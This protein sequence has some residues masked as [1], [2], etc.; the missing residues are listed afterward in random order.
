MFFCC[1]FIAAAAQPAPDLCAQ[2]NDERVIAGLAP[3]VVSDSLTYVAET[4]RRDQNTNYRPGALCTDH[5]WNDN[6]PYWTSCCYEMSRPN[7]Q[8]MFVKPAELTPFAA[9]GYE[10]SAYGCGSV[11]CLLGAW[12]RS[13]SHAKVIFARDMRSVGCAISSF[14]VSCCW[15][16]RDIDPLTYPGCFRRALPPIPNDRE[17]RLN[18]CNATTAVPT[19]SP[20]A[21]PTAVPTVS[22]TKRMHTPKPTRRRKINEFHS[23]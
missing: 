6:S 17:P 11:S 9:T 1:L 15:F 12:L 18:Q 19:M 3:L 14:K 4:H 7:S 8:C 10:I 13:P 20:T 16:S 23:Q 2:I 22:P 21:G 5:S